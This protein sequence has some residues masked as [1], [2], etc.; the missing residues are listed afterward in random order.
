MNKILPFLL[1]ASSVAFS[2]ASNEDLGKIMT[3]AVVEQ[4]LNMTPLFALAFCIA[5]FFIFIQKKSQKTIQVCGSLFALVFAIGL[6]TWILDFIA[7]H[8]FVFFLLGAGLVFGC[9]I[10]FMVFSPPSPPKKQNEYEAQ[11]DKNNP[12]YEGPR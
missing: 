9:L 5:L 2:G 6:V 10:L 7:S 8:A 12:F 11:K 3:G 4:G 1:L